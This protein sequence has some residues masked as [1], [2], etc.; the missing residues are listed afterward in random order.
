MMMMMG[1]SLLQEKDA[2]ATETA[3]KLAAAMA[4]MK[5][6]ISG[7]LRKARRSSKTQRMWSL[8]HSGVAWIIDNVKGFYG[9]EICSRE[10]HCLQLTRMRNFVK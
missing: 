8:L 7:L 1:M 9:G 4:I 3:V 10:G 5:T 6:N 2:S